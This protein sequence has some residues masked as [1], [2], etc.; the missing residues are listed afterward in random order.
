[1]SETQSDSILFPVLD[2]QY[3]QDLAACG[4]VLSLEQGDILFKEGDTTYGFYI[5]LSGQ[6][7]VTKYLG[8]EEI[9]LTLHSRGEFTGNLTMLTGGVS[10][11]TATS[12][13]SS[14]V[15]QFKGFKELLKACPQSIDVFVPALAERSKNL[16][17][18][19]REQ[20]KLAA[21]GKLSAG[22]EIGRAHV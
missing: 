2:N 12:I 14:Q 20:E 9:V 3:L 11:T 19:L 10:Q 13:Q 17:I 15:I 8:L 5:V 1:M 4:T 6:I 21:L 7:K 18:K 22:L 16:E